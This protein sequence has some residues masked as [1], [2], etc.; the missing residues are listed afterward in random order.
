M[1]ILASD[2]TSAINYTY[3]SSIFNLHSDGASGVVISSWTCDEEPV[4]PTPSGIETIVSDWMDT[5]S[6]YLGAF[7]VERFQSE[8]FDILPS[9]LSS[10]DL[11]LEFGAL[12]T[13]A[14]NKDFIG[15]VQYLNL[16]LGNGIATQ[17]DVDTVSAIVTSQGIIL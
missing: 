11:R 3:P 1:I 14:E 8:L 4:A 5:Q 10:I 17:N 9:G 16:L 13:F 6:Y 2:A 7:D 15:M 12:N